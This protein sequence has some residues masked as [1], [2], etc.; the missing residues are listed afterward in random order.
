MEGCEEPAHRTGLL[1]VTAEGVCRCST[2]HEGEKPSG[3][4][5]YVQRAPL[6]VEVL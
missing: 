3:W 6:L 4:L 5:L 2:C 1:E